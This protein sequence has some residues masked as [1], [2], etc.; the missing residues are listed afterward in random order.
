MAVVFEGGLEHKA[1]VIEMLDFVLGFEDLVDK[2]GCYEHDK[3]QAQRQPKEGTKDL[4]AH[5]ACPMWGSKK[6]KDRAWGE[7]I[8]KYL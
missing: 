2:D 5:D 6:R 4:F 7:L 1:K 3:E 8:V